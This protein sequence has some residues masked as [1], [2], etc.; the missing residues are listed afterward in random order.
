MKTLCVVM[1][2]IAVLLSC[3]S[4]S[5]GGQQQKSLTDSLVGRWVLREMSGGIM[6]EHR[7]FDST[8]VITYSFSDAG[9]FWM[10]ANGDTVHATTF[11]VDEVRRI[12]AYGVEFMPASDIE[13]LSGTQLTLSDRAA[14]GYQLT[15]IKATAEQ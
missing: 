15:F 6:G 3:E 10:V 2:L 4:P 9:K 1:G 11:T 8:D 13:A 7:V 12:L 5:D 14:D